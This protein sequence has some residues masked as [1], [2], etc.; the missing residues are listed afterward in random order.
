MHLNDHLQKA[1]G[2]GISNRTESAVAAGKAESGFPLYETERGLAV[3]SVSYKAAAGPQ[4]VFVCTVKDVRGAVSRPRAP[5]ARPYP[6]ARVWVRFEVNFELVPPF[7]AWQ[8]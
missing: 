5:R 3:I 6:T 7:F 2:R 1:T 4:R 8:L